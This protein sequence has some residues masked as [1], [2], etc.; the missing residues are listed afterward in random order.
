MRGFKSTPMRNQPASWWYAH[1][2]AVV[3]SELDV[4]LKLGSD[5]E[6]RNLSEAEQDQIKKSR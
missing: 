5:V 2:V 1:I 6:W 4:E 3:R